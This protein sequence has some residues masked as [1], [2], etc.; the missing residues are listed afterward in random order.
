MVV[1]PYWKMQRQKQMHY[2]DFNVLDKTKFR[3]HFY[4]FAYLLN[5]ELVFELRFDLKF[6]QVKQLTLIITKM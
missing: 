2:V 6:L 1:Q 4:N 3:L 5:I